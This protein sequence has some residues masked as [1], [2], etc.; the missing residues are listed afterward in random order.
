LIFSSARAGVPNIFWQP[1]DGTGTAER[2]MPVVD[3]KTGTGAPDNTRY[4]YAVSPDG[5][6]LVFREDTAS[7]GNDLMM[8]SLQGELRAQPIIATSFSERNAEISPDGRWLAY[9]S[10]ESGRYEIYVR[11]FPEVDRGRWQVSSG[12]GTRPLWARSGRELFY[13]TL[14]GLALMSLPV[15]AAPAFKPGKA[16]EVFNTAA[17]VVIGD[18]GG[19]VGRMHDVSLD[20]RRFLMVKPGSASESDQHAPLP[21]MI[22]VQNWFEELKRRVPVP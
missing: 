15:T 14:D 10:N 22:V 3:M 21:S 17:Y 13:V 2:L 20:D 6:W 8:M 9:E 16:T 11:P 1:A 12:G 7:G 4:P 18:G 19:D 5:A